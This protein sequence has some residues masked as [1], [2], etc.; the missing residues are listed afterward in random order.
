MAQIKTI[1]SNGQI[2]L[3]KEFAGQN[4]LIDNSENGVW[5]I[6]IGKFIP[7]NEQWLLEK[8]NSKKL[9][10]ALDW[11][12]KSKPNHTDLA[13]LKNSLS[14]SRFNMGVNLL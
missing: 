7:H 12:S 8:D 4:V 11:A 10:E 13:E 2:S 6:K 3:E 5:T 14:L 1:A 9:D